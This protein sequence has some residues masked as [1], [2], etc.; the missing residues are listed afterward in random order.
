MSFL[1]GH[2]CKAEGDHGATPGAG[3][4]NAQSVS[5][6]HTACQVGASLT[7]SDVLPKSLSSLLTSDAN[8][9]QQNGTGSLVQSTGA[10]GGTVSM[11]MDHHHQ[12][13]LPDKH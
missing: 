5:L 7:S 11:T 12:L 4:A 13:N 9:Q 6:Q 8:H 1:S 2:G 3:G 10:S